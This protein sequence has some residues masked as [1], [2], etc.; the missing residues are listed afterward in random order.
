M[1]QFLVYMAAPFA[2]SLVLVMIHAYLGLHVL[3]RGVIF[4]DLALAQI[5]AMGAD[6][7]LVRID[8]DVVSI[9]GTGKGADTALVIRPAISKRLF[10][11]RVKKIL[12]KPI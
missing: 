9:A 12:A 4:V 3:A 10:D 2:A 7:G 1:N 5:A 6:A 8:E 11:L